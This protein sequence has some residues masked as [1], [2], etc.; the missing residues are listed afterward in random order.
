[1]RNFLLI[2]FLFVANQ[3]F[4]QK[5]N[6]SG[7]VQSEENGSAIS[8]ANLLFNNA[9]SQTDT[10]GFF[11][12]VVEANKSIRVKIKHPA[13]F[14]FEQKLVFTKDTQL[15]FFVK[16]LVQNL[17]EVT[18]KA[19]KENE[20]GISR[21]NNVE[22]TT[23]FAG[24]KSE[25]VYLQ[26]LNANLATNNSRQIFSKVPGINIFEN[27]GSGTTIGIGGRGLNPNR[28]SNFNTRQN[29]YDISADAL[30]YPESYYTPPT[31]AI[32]RIEILR[33]AAGLQFGTQFGGMINYKF[34]EAP[35]NKKLSGDFR[36][37]AGS[38][39]L[40]NSFNRIAGTHKKI[41]YNTFYQYKKYTGWR[42]RSKLNSH[43]AFASIGY[44]VNEKLFIKGEYT[45][46]NY[47][48]QQ[49]GGLTD[50]QFENNP[51]MVTRQR[52]WFKV[53]WNLASVSADYKINDK[54]LLNFRSFGLIAGRDA[55]GVLTPANRADDTSSFRNLLHDEYQN[56][57]AELR[58]LKRY[59]LFNQ[60]SHFLIGARYYSGQT[61]RKQGEASKDSDADFSFLNP[62]DLE[63][64]EYLFPSANYAVFVENIF[65]LTKKWSVTPGLRYEF[66]HT[67]SEGYYRLLNRNGAGTIILDQKIYDNRINERDFLLAG[68]GTQYKL[69]PAIEF[70]AN[71]SQNYRSINFNDMR[72]VNPNFQV[73]PQLSDERG[74]TADGGIRGAIKDL[75]YF[76][77]SVF[78]LKYNDRIGTDLRVDSNTFQ[79]VRY[80]TNIGNSR[81]AGIEAVAEVDW[82]KLINKTSKHRLSTFVN[83]SY[84]DAIY[85]SENPAFSAKKVEFVPNTIF[86]S[87]VTYG[88]KTMKITLLYSHVGEQYSEATNSA[89]SSSGIYGIIPTYNVLDLSASYTYKSFTLSA[90]VNNLTNRFY[91]TRRAEG[92]PGPGII[93]ADP[94]NLYAT[95][96]YFF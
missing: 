79:I 81:N 7:S 17:D 41:S 89:S 34:I 21:L 59:T 60:Y 44:Q 33:G 62:N 42:E 45:F 8:N 5:I 16:S 37:T 1:M 91:F 46:M 39:G 90:G 30:G 57:G 3:I 48:A 66:I 51:L 63:N 55:L 35:A 82:M 70:Y 14:N 40:I 25:A 78:L 85:Q 69:K 65:Q 26:D 52:N 95:L 73:D 94:L 74:Y 47:V 96:R 93:P 28:I 71:F 31:E 29:G 50:T 92:Y 53:N 80:R 32:D 9:L 27:D 36:Q 4:S 75:L 13:C 49:P 43:N 56:Y 38:F 61:Q 76:D 87:G 6:V 67:S 64:S 19:Q 18:V 11:S 68:I 54:A 10:N 72:V 22:G 2:A 20:F 23:I 86:R 15:V 84:I 58:L 83:I 24:K 12:I 77:V 88:F